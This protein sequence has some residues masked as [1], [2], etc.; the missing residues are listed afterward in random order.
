MKTKVRYVTRELT[1][2]AYERAVKIR[3]NNLRY[4]A[5]AVATLEGAS[6]EKLS[7]VGLEI[8]KGKVLENLGKYAAKLTDPEAKANEFWK[9]IGSNHFDCNILEAIYHDGL[10]IEY[11]GFNK[12]T[13]D[14]QIAFGVLGA[15]VIYN[16]RRETQKF[17]GL[18]K[19]E[20]QNMLHEAYAEKRYR[21]QLAWEKANG[22]TEESK[23]KDAQ[24]AA[25][26]LKGL[27]ED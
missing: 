23:A 4:V 1:V 10:E 26:L 24:E 2:K 19:F 17:G 20:Y 21:D 16:H 5:S 3:K 22:I 8:P 6:G 12:L 15:W 27:F 11:D 7:K 25:K 18:T 13:S 9:V 14:Q